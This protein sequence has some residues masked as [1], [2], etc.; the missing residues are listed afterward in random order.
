MTSNG[1]ATGIPNSNVDWYKQWWAAQVMAYE[2]AWGLDLL[3]VEDVG[4]LEQPAVGLS[5]GCGYGNYSK[6][7]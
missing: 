7:P 6:E 3:D 2:K 1:R 5:E 4:Q